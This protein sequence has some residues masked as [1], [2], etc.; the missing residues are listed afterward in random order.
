MTQLDII[1]GT[2]VT[3]VIR[4]RPNRFV[5]TVEFGPDIARV[6][7]SDPGA[8]IDIIVPGNDIICR[9]V[10]DPTRSTSYDAIAVIVNEVAVSVRTAY[11]N[12]LFVESLN[13]DAIPQ[14]ERYSIRSRE[15]SL[16]G[17]GRTDF[18]LE[19][20]K[21]NDVYVEVKSCTYVEDGVA[22]FP[23]RQSARGRRH[24]QALENLVTEGTESHV[25]FV[26][27]RPDADRFAP[28]ESVDPEF[29]SLLASAH[30]SGVGVHAMQTRF[31]PPAYYLERPC[32]PIDLPS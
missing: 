25:V 21:E 16:P 23:D 17:H 18:Y 15:P 10:Q 19:D 20:P 9:P 31:E 8:L 13:C 29:A 30:E 14:F 28:F 1:E 12:E 6:H 22:K 4:D 27:Q 2:L 32:L 24:V 5:V 7:L 3:G 11:A 26:V